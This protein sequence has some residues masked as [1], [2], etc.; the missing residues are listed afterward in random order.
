MAASGGS[1]GGAHVDLRGAVI[2]G[3]SVD[4]ARIIGNLVKKHMDGYNRRN[5]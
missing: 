5:G 2:A 3:E 1:V 4:S